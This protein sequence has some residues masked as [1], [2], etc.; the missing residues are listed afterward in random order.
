MNAHKLRWKC[1][2]Y[3]PLLWIWFIFNIT[4]GIFFGFIHQAGVLP[5]TKYIANDLH[6]SSSTQEA[7]FIWSHTYMPPTFQ[8]LR[9]SERSKL[10]KKNRNRTDQDFPSYYLH[11]NIS[12]NFYDLGGKD[13]FSGNI[14]FKRK[15]IVKMIYLVWTFNIF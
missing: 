3:K 12:V 7:N 1:G 14:F 13:I 2:N 4:C 11:T 6:F 5:A 10:R 15:L 8:M 9:Q